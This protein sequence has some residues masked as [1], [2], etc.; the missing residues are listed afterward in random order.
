MVAE[1]AENSKRPALEELAPGVREAVDCVLNDPMPD[2]LTRHALESLRHQTSQYPRKSRRRIM[3][4]TVPA[5][6]ASI[7]LIVL[8]AYFRA[9]QTNGGRSVTSPV[10]PTTRHDAAASANDSQTAWAYTQAA[11]QSPRRRCAARPP[12]AS[13]DHGEFAVFA[14][15][16]VSPF[17]TT[18]TLGTGLHKFK[19]LF[20]EIT[21]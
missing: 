18:N 3:S 17:N 6:A 16:S 20:R 11:R 2:D 15:T 4:W 5:I 7:V 12:I 9:V 8:A 10:L 14:R 19:C 21:K 1:R 13:I